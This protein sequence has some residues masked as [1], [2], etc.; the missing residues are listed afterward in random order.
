PGGA[1]AALAA[2]RHPRRAYHQ[3]RGRPDGDRRLHAPLAFLRRL[4]MQAP[5]GPS[6]KIVMLGAA[7][8]T[9]GSVASVLEAYRS[10]GL[11][12]RWPLECVVT[13][14]DG[15][16]ME[17]AKITLRGLRRFAE[18]V[19]RERGVVLHA[20]CTAEGFWRDGLFIALA[21]AARW[22]VLLQL[23]GA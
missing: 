8:E 19:G 17:R 3:P 16:P 4:P 1:R 13:H 2:R 15:L 7:P 21:A 10:G 23:H 14:G 12:D 22:P 5:I 20:H 18:L 11:F 9:R 6:P